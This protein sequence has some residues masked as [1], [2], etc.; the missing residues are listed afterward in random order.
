M[1]P[2]SPFFIT[3]QQEVDRS[4]IVGSSSRSKIVSGD[5][6]IF[7]TNYLN[8]QQIMETDILANPSSG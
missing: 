5:N 3:E 2:N 7:N 8:R 1:S 4:L 6:E